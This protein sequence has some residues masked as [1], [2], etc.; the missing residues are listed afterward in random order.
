MLIFQE[1]ESVSIID[2]IKPI[3]LEDYFWVLD[4][5]MRDF[6][7]TP[8]NVIESITSPGIELLVDNFS[9]IVPAAWNIMIVDPETSELDISDVASVL[10]KKF[11]AFSYGFK[12]YMPEHHV[13]EAIDYHPMHESFS[14]SL[15]KNHM[16][17]HPIDET[18]WINVSPADSYNKHF[19]NTILTGD[20]I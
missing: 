17:C 5:E 20:I 14:P 13:I 2:T 7:L 12:S 9:F 8:L 15:S 1:S 19:R 3:L 18:R 11:H 10:G 4:L 16:L 6:T